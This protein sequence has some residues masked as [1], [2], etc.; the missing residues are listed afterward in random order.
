MWDEPYD[1]AAAKA[2][3]EVLRACWFATE[4]SGAAA[5]AATQVGMGVEEGGFGKGRGWA[6]GRGGEK[7]W[8]VVREECLIHM[9]DGRQGVVVLN[10]FANVRSSHTLCP[11]APPHSR[12]VSGATHFSCCV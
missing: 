7:G 8:G 11:L 5:A 2:T 1:E 9:K 3:V 6:G 12:F 10:Q 4:G